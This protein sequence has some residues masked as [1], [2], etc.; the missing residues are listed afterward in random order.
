MVQPQRTVIR[1]GRVLTMTPGDDASVR[2]ILVEG[3]RIVAMAPNLDAPDAVHIDATGCI[4]H[5]GFVDTHRHVWQT[6]LRTV[7]TDWSLYDY[8]ALM[9]CVY[10]HFYDAEDAYLGNF[11]GA[12]EALNA[13]VTTVVDHCHI[14]NSPDHAHEAARGLVDAG[15]RAQFCYGFWPNP[16]EVS[17]FTVVPGEPWRFE[18]A[19]SLRRGLLSSDD[20]PVR[21]G[22]APSELEG[23]PFELSVTEIKAARELGAS[24]ISMHVAMGAYDGGAHMVQRLHDAGLLGADMLF[25]HGAALTRPELDLIASAGAGLSSTPETELQMGM[26]I[27]VTARALEAGVAAS[28]GVDIVSNYSGDMFTQVRLLLQTMRAQAN[29]AYEREGKAP[30]TILPKA[31]ELLRLATAGGARAAGLGGSVGMLEPGRKADIVVTRT[32]AIHMTPATHPVGALV[33]GANQGDVD[34]VIVNG[35]IVKRDGRLVGVDWPTLSQRLTASAQRILER[36][37]KVDATPIRGFVGTLFHNL[38]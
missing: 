3:D 13:G 28:I 5:P 32:D 4:V 26:G 35:R 36:A 17:P 12:L 16:K 37:A 33:L 25:V 14:I 29:L 22:V 31:D 27:P 18:T 24:C 9:R 21:F 2:D 38:A 10:S 6:Q 23:M 11:V 8:V 7:A 1:G 34:T 15:I 19:A 30:R 20:A